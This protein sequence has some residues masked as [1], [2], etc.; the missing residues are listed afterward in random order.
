MKGNASQDLGLSL[1][2]LLIAIAIL[3]F[4]A[5]GLAGAMGMSMEVFSRTEN[6]SQSRTEIAHRI[7]LRSFLTNAIPPSQLTKYKKQFEG[8][9][10][11]LVF[12]SLTETPF[13]PAAVAS[14]V[15]ITTDATV[16][17]F[18]LTTIDKNGEPIKK[19]THNL[20]TNIEDLK[21][22][23]YGTFE[24]DTAWHSEWRDPHRLPLLVRVT[25]H[26]GSL[27]EWPDFIVRLGL[28]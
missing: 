26:A 8:T 21:I 17:R 16:L 13:E 15:E 14:M 6:L 27:P 28:E 11:S 10:D 1:M 3:M 18:A 24:G 25:A 9:S 12:F 20:T 4:I 5:I 22:G 7:R 2:E 19:T 23:Y